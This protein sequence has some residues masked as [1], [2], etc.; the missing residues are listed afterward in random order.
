MRYWNLVALLW[1]IML[2]PCSSANAQAG[3]RTRDL[4]ANAALKYWQGFALLPAMDQN[5]EKMLNE[6][7]KVPLDAA[8]LKLIDES[9]QSITYLQ[10]GAAIDRCDWG[11][12]YDEG[13]RLLVPHG[14]KSRTLARLA[15]LDA[16][17]E[18]EQ[19]HW[20]A[21]WDDVVALLRLAR[22]V[23]SDPIMINQLVGCA[24]E[25]I[26]IDAAAPYLKELKS[27]QPAPLAGVL[28]SLTA[29][30]TLSQMVLVEKRLGP[31]WLIKELKKAEQQKQGS[32]QQVWK[33]LFEIPGEG[34]QPRRDLV[35][36][37]QTLEQ[38]V[39][40]MEEI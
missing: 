17:H 23:E 35:Q 30:P 40:I 5:Q 8:A 38:A 21:G 12:D 37:A 18:F 6:W 10:Q 36:S 31:I 26:A 34:E 2:L 39:Q 7:N 22:H 15:A 13:I 14:V 28:D 11:L 16:R 19:A 27:V 24:I 3:D 33:G 29:A 32:W 25:G 20:K 4:G 1:S 9:R